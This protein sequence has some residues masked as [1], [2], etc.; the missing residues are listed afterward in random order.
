MVVV[1]TSVE[2]CTI[3]AAIEIVLVVGIAVV[4]VIVIIVVVETTVV[5][6]VVNIPVVVWVVIVVGIVEAK[7]FKYISYHYLF[8]TIALLMGKFTTKLKQLSFIK[9]TC[10]LSIVWIYTIST[11]M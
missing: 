7:A 8:D 4:A 3:N 1:G 10:A 5:D 9:I 11:T 2:D 6:V